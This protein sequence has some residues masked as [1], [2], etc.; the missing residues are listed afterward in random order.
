MAKPSGNIE[1][2]YHYAHKHSDT[3][4]TK[5]T[6]RTLEEGDDVSLDTWLLHRGGTKSSVVLYAAATS[7]NK[8]MTF[9]KNI[10]YLQLRVSRV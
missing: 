7:D 3:A 4:V 2:D 1:K 10:A 9:T 8:V 6:V 5:S